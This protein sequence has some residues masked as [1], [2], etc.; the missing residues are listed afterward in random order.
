MKKTLYIAKEVISWVLLISMLILCIFTVYQSVTNENKG[1]GTFLF[2]Y[3]PVVILTG[4]ME[5]YMK[6]NGVVLTKAVDDI[7][8]LEVGDVIS[9]HVQSEKG[10][11]LRITH[12]IIDIEGELIYTKGDNNNV[13]DG[14]ALTMENVE[15]K[16]VA[17]FNGTAWLVN[18]WQ[19]ST[20]GKV[21]IVSFGAAFIMLYF[22]L[23]MLVR[24]LIEKIKG[25]IKGNT[26]ETLT[27]NASSFDPSLVKT[28]AGNSEE[29]AAQSSEIPEK[30]KK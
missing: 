12:R 24:G 26:Q 28:P 15:A 9:Y 19:G 6:V 2:G 29:K 5:P 13:A 7:E 25:K 8:E 14:Y 11:L 20:A 16:A 17:V 21:M 30:L 10:N 18:K 3:R 23:K 4:S 22:C 1:E 27:E